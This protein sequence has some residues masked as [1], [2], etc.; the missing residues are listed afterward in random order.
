MKQIRK[1]IVLLVLSVGAGSIPVFGKPF[2]EGPYLG[3][4]S[5]HASGKRLGPSLR[6][7]RPC[8]TIDADRCIAHA[9]C[10]PL[11]F[12]WYSPI[13]LDLFDFYTA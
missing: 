10:S 3:Q 11:R 9:F 4:I 6:M 12:L 8:V 7:E 5:G 2:A 13:G 1:R